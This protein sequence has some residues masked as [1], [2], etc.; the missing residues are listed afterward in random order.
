ML[1]TAILFSVYLR[2]FVFR[3]LLTISLQVW[4]FKRVVL[5]LAAFELKRLPL[6][7]DMC[8]FT[9]SL[10]WTRKLSLRS[11][12]VFSTNFLWNWMLQDNETVYIYELIVALITKN[13]FHLYLFK[14]HSTKI[15]YFTIV[16]T[17]SLWGTY[18][19]VVKYSATVREKF[20]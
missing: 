1:S 19:C 3:N 5:P 14:Y 20:M 2:S 9:L 16:L 11:R 10:P 15:L 8:I 18:I 17:I 7:E 4:S 6:T 13:F 12:R